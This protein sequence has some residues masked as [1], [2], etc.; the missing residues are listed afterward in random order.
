ML[1]TLLVLITSVLLLGACTTEPGTAE[2]TETA[3]DGARQTSGA[4]DEAI[5]TTETDVPTATPAEAQQESDAPTATAGIQGLSATPVPPTATLPAPTQAAS[6][7]T[8]TRTSTTAAATATPMP[9]TPVPPTATSVPPTATPA[10]DA[11]GPWYTSSHHSAD[12]YYCAADDGWRGLSPSY[13]QEYPSE[14][15]LLAVWAGRRVKHPESVC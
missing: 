5:P 11:K 12:Y 15:A 13:L 7:P 3:T 2:P 14:A 1:R 9:P 4:S 8:A 10:T 6:A